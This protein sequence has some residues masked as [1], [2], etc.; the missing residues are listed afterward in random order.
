MTQNASESM[1]KIVTISEFFVSANE[2]SSQNPPVR[3]RAFS[4][5]RFMIKVNWKVKMYYLLYAIRI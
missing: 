2:D 3:L 4:K 5:R 1:T